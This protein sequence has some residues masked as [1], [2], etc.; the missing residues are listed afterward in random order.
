MCVCVTSDVCVRD[1]Q[2]ATRVQV[3]E[4]GTLW[5]FW[6]SRKEALRAEGTAFQWK[7][8]LW[9]VSQVAE[10]LVHMHR[11]GVVH[12][13]VRPGNVLVTGVDG[14]SGLPSVVIADFG[15]SCVVGTSDGSRHVSGRRK[16]G[17]PGAVSVEV[18]TRED[19]NALGALMG[20][21]MGDVG[22]GEGVDEGEGRWGEGAG[23]VVSGIRDGV[24][25]VKECEGRE[26]G[27]CPTML[28]VLAR[29]KVWL[30][31]LC[32]VTARR[33]GEWVGH[34]GL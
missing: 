17:V 32:D 8:V 14:D 34:C 33:G 26:D 21:M 23:G 10:G 31:G 5:T 16:F 24:R 9:I 25:L 3:E 1:T 18:S 4:Y 7:T 19:V 22:V 11:H 20:E 15:V 13:D 12:C 29:L 6:L 27:V 28:K 2:W 30:S